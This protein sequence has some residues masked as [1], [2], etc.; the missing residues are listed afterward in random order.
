MRN[1]FAADIGDFG[2]YGLLR[3]L[4][5]GLAGCEQDKP[6]GYGDGGRALRLGVIWYYVATNGPLPPMGQAFNFI[7]NPNQHEQRLIECDP[8]LF[9][10]LSNLIA[11]A[12]RA[13][14]AIEDSSVL[15]DDT[16]YFREPVNGPGTRAE[17]FRRAGD[18]VRNCNLVFLDPDKGLVDDG[19]NPDAVGPEH[20]TYQEAA[21][22]WMQGKSLV[23]YQ[24]L[25][26]NGNAE[27]QIQ[28]HVDQLRN[29]LGIN[30]PAGEII[31][32]WFHRRFARIFYVIPNPANPEVAQLLRERIDA[33]LECC[34]GTGRS[35]HFTRVDC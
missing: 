31:A 12:Q 16:V 34:W 11:T 19:G 26:R 3:T 7:L 8:R 6:T 33:F 17:W 4:T 29:A 9:E 35:P 32:L 21:Q 10:I 15:P 14:E 18:A 13:V 24:S 28:A 30:G 25:K 22:L 5:R 27:E 2:K 20:A 23:I 1:E